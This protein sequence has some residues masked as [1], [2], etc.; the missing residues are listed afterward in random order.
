MKRIAFTSVVVTAVLLIMASLSSARLRRGPEVDIFV[1]V[2]P[3]YRY[4]PPPYYVYP[5]VIYPAPVVIYPAP[6]VVP[7]PV[8][9]APAP[10]YVAPPPTPG[11]AYWYYCQGFR[12]YYPT[13]TN[14]PEAW[15]AVPAR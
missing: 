6:V 15:I 2:G 9:V 3:V 10:V 12:G 11:P 7:P 14:C 1:G 5:P 8:Y 4:S 13:V